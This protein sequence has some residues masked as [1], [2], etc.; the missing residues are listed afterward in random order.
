MPEVV[1]LPDVR[2]ERE[3]E[4]S[5]DERE[6]H[7]DDAGDNEADEERERDCLDFNADKRDVVL[8]VTLASGLT[9]CPPFVGGSSKTLERLLGG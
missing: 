5:R 4:D 2:R 8:G 3:G 9:A 6:E 7:L 1:E